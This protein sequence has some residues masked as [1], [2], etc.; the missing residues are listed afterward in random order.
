MIAH[1][2]RKARMMTKIGRYATLAALAS[3][4]T[5]AACAGTGVDAPVDEVTFTPAT[6]D[7]DP[8]IGITLPEGFCGVVYANN[9]GRARH[10]AINDNGDVYVATQAVRRRRGDSEAPPPRPPM[11]ALRDTDGDGKADVEEDFGDQRGGT[12]MDV[13][14]GFLYFST[15]STVY[16][17][18]LTG[19][20][21]ARQ[22]DF[23]LHADRQV[24]G[25]AFRNLCVDFET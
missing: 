9:L 8:D 4:A 12:G 24:V 22:Q 10:I 5:L 3:L 18:Q 6:F 11:R 13:Y 25:V 1:P 16:R 17:Y 21:L 20:G 19:I 2:Q 15:P 7:C 23:R 14:N